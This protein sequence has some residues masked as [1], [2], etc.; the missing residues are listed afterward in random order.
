MKQ[1]PPR[2][3]AYSL[4]S[5]IE[6][7]PVKRKF[8]KPYWYLKTDSVGAFTC[9]TKA[10]AFEFLKARLEK[11]NMNDCEL[12]ESLRKRHDLILLYPEHYNKKGDI[13]VERYDK[14]D[15]HEADEV[16]MLFWLSDQ[17]HSMRGAE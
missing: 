2:P 5:F 17:G 9:Q 6:L 10:Q 13:Y 11:T 14:H 15:W 1:R 12:Y 8:Q 7:K 16:D 4:P 3:K